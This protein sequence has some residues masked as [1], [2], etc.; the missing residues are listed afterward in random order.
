[1]YADV[2]LLYDS[3][4]ITILSF[5]MIERPVLVD[6]SLLDSVDLR[7]PVMLACM[8]P[9]PIPPLQQR[10]TNIIHLFGLKRYGYYLR[11]SYIGLDALTYVY[12]Q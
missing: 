8:S 3:G 12:K 4:L 1:M 2:V 7:Y 5:G 6:T 11:P 10:T 9:P